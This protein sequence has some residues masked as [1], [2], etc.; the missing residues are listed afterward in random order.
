MVFG[1]PRQD[2]LIAYLIE[3]MPEQIVRERLE[4]L[5]IDLRPPPL[6]T[7][8]G[9][10]A[11][12]S[13]IHLL[14]NP[15]AGSLGRTIV[16]ALD[17][18]PLVMGEHCNNHDHPVAQALRAV[19]DHL[20]QMDV[21]NGGSRTGWDTFYEHR[22]RWIDVPRVW[23]WD[24]RKRV[25]T[26]DDLVITLLLDCDRDGVIVAL[27]ADWE[28]GA[29]IVPLQ[30]AQR[31]ADARRATLPEILE[32]L[33]REGFEVIPDR[34]YLP[35]GNTHEALGVVL[36]GRFYSQDDLAQDAGV[37]A[38]IERLVEAYDEAYKTGLAHPTRDEWKAMD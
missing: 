9:R 6:H 21:A 11:H 29:G 25:H 26:G 7:R 3:R 30:S 14:H 13:T 4:T 27:A 22:R 18:Y 19:A 31:F 8:S 24:E 2:D 34:E 10:P 32:P 23:L 28:E 12:Q 33:S 15:P 1:Q 37:L 16:H 35:I 17:R 20:A 38:G 36:A 5:Q